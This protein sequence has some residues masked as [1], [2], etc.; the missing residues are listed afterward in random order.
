MKTR[1]I[2]Q[3]GFTLVELMILIAVLSIILAL[4][5][6]RLNFQD[7]LLKKEAYLLCWNIRKVRM[8]NMTDGT[9]RQ[10]ELTATTYKI[11]NGPRDLEIYHFDD[12][13][14]I[15]DNLDSDPFVSR[16]KFSYYG[17]PNESG[18]IMIRNTKTKRYME[19]TIVPS[20]GR[21]L[22]KNE[23]KTLQY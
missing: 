7:M 19:I 23:I 12:S 6:P 10:M 1:I 4:V 21:V 8:Q 2:V 5:L 16:L 13:I 3:K 14:Q 18:T 17:S 9:E 15:W 20:S 22:L 11:Q